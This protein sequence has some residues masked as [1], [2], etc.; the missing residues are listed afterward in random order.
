MSTRRINGSMLLH[1]IR[2][3]WAAGATSTGLLGKLTATAW[4]LN[5]AR[6]QGRGIAQLVGFLGIAADI[7]WLKLLMGAD[8][9]G[10]VCCGPGVRLPHGGRLLNINPAATIGSNVTIQQHV[11]IGNNLGHTEAPTIGDNVFIGPRASILGGVQIGRGARV[12]AH[13]VVLTDVPVDTLI[14]GPRAAIR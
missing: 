2:A 14:A 13:A 9:P 1:L 12:G 4:R 10:E 5:Q 11:I 6:A 8:L 7:V 3:D